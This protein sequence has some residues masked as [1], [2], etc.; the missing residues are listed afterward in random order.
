MKY[1]LDTKKRARQYL[2]LPFIVLMSIPLVTLDIFLEFYHRVCFWLLH[3][4]YVKRGQYIRIDRHKLKYL[5]YNRKFFCAYCGYANGLLGY[6]VKI[7]G[8]TEAY[9]CGI[10]HKTDETFNNPAHH[11]KF[12]KYGDEKAFR[13]KYPNA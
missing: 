3:I 10:K 13:K 7:S 9:W 6:A 1:L 4:P 11:K 5:N 8:I 2:S 12:L